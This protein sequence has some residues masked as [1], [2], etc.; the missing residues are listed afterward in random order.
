MNAKPELHGMLKS[1]PVFSDCSP[2]ELAALAECFEEK[3]LPEGRD[4]YRAGEA[5]RYFYLI[6]NGAVSLWQRRGKEEE[7]TAL[8]GPGDAF[9]A[10]ALADSPV[11]SSSAHAEVDTVVLRAASEPLCG[12]LEQI[13]GAPEALRTILRGH[14]LTA[15]VRFPWLAPEETVYLATRKSEAMLAPGLSLPGLIALISLIAVPVFLHLRWPQWTLL[16]P[17]AGVLAALA[18]GVWQALDWSNDFYLVTNRRVVVIRRIPLVYDDRQESPL[19]RIQSVSVTRSVFQRMLGFGDVVIRTFTRQMVFDSIPDPQTAAR[20]LDSIR[21]LRGSRDTE[22]DREEIGRMLSERIKPRGDDGTGDEPSDPAPAV[23]AAQPE[24]PGRESFGRLQTRM[25]SGDTVTYRKHVF[26]LIRNVF[27]PVL[28]VLFGI[29]IASVMLVGVF[30]FSRLTGVAAGIGVLALGLAWGAYEYLDWANDLY[31]VTGEQILAVHRKPL[32]DEERRAAVLDNILSL[33]YDRPS[34]LARLMNFGTVV[35]TVGQVNFIFEEVSDP[36]HVQ[37][38]IFR[39]M[40]SRKKWREEAERRQR[41]KEI[42]DWITTYH[43]LTRESDGGREEEQ[44]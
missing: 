21:K 6:V 3:T 12:R 16:L 29:A 23:I 9:G 30:P 44:S 20:L 40:E 7:Q 38:D 22:A 24:K 19:D 27:L 34:L 17:A 11:R 31:Q 13:P 2:D 42:A 26:F 35:A 15:R 8:L 43:D 4:V 39:R 36:V 41:R 28:L 32:G 25:E 5:G 1:F 33:E 18:L 14:R 10:E 37:E